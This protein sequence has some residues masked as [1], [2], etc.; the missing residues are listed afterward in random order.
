MSTGPGVGV[1]VM[2]VA[3]AL[4]TVVAGVFIVLQIFSKPRRPGD[5]NP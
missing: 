1:W 4:T 5:P 2:A 3:L